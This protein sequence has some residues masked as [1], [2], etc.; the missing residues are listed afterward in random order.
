[1]TPEQKRNWDA[2][3]KWPEFELDRPD[4]PLLEA[5]DAELTRLRE[6]RDAL[7]DALK[8]AR[9]ELAYGERQ[10]AHDKVCEVISSVEGAA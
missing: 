4:Q 2:L 3:V 5:V 10:E 9:R 7:L 6:Q 8:M 1:M